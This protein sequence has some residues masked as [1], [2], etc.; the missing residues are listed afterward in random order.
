[1]REIERVEGEI[2]RGIGDG[3]IYAGIRGCGEGVGDRTV[4]GGDA[5]LI[6][7]GDWNQEVDVAERWGK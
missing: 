5:Q 1:M 3:E 2:E 6:E 7:K 4:G